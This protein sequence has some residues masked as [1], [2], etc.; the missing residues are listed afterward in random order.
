MTSTRYLA[1]R[2]RGACCMTSQATACSQQ[3]RARCR[4]CQYFTTAASLSSALTR[5]LLQ[6]T[7][8]AGVAV[9]GYVAVTVTDQGGALFQD[10]QQGFL[11]I[12]RESR[13]KNQASLYSLTSRVVAIDKIRSTVT[14]ERPLPWNATSEFFGQLHRWE[15][16]LT[17]VGI[18]GLSFEFA[19]RRYQGHFKVRAG[20]ACH[21]TRLFPFCPWC[22]P[23][24]TIAPWQTIVARPLQYAASRHWWTGRTPSTVG[25]WRVRAGGWVERRAAAEP[26]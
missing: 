24:H 2:I 18:E 16:R 6:V 3:G 13:C 15:P 9:G 22:A 7:S 23:A 25:C 5:P 12:C 19:S 17:N 10:L 8:L 26:G 14:L 1:S 20:S 4:A 21:G 11:P